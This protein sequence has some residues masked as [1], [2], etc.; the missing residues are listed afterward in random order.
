ML[1]VA[2]LPMQHPCNF[3]SFTQIA[4]KGPCPQGIS[5]AALA[6]LRCRNAALPHM[7]ARVC[8]T[9]CCAVLTYCRAAT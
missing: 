9:I 1:M 5:Q 2:S 3:Q 7:L 8:T 4:L 6:V